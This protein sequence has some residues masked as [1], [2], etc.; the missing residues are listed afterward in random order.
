MAV[1]DLIGLPQ[2]AALWRWQPDVRYWLI[3]AGA[4]SDADLQ[5]LD[6]IPALWFRLE[7]ADD[8]AQ[9]VAVAAAVLGWLSRHPDYAA[10]RA[11]FAEFLAQMAPPPSADIPIKEEWLDMQSRLL[12]RAEQWTQA[13]LQEGRQQGLQEG[14][15]EGEA[16]LLLR[17]LERR[18]GPVPEK[19]SE[20]IRAADSIA[21]EE[22]G[23]RLLDAGS[24]E[25]VIGETPA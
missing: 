21:L 1:R 13:W 11:V 2:D 15:Q 14:R 18:F 7:I 9:V 20:R 23:L 24:I 5:A 17:M 6:S 8:P 19:V 12:A 16:A 22:W 3:D 4:F 25:D 10:L